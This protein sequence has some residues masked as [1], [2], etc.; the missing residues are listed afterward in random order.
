MRSSSKALS[1]AAKCIYFF[2]NIGDT[3][4]LLYTF[5]FRV[6]SHSVPSLRASLHDG[7]WNRTMENDLFSWS[8]FNDPNSVKSQFTKSLGPSL[9]VNCMWT[10]RNDHAPKSECVDFFLNICSK[11]EVLRKKNSSLTIL[12]S[13]L[14]LLYPKRNSFKIYY[15]NISLPWALAFFYYSTSFATPTTK[16]VGPC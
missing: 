4:M 12:L 2:C 5:M 6:T 9:G 13:C 14:H 3:F 10:K 16:V 7:P 11:R 15:Y 1:I 8:N